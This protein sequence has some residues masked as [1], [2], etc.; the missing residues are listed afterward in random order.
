MGL[1]LLVLVLIVT[2]LWLWMGR[3]NKRGRS[4][5][6]ITATVFFVVLTAGESALLIALHAGRLLYLSFILLSLVYW[7][8]GL[9]AIVL[10]WRRSSSDYYIAVSNWSKATREAARKPHGQPAARQVTD[11]D[12]D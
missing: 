7:L 11:P 12:P 10:L 3:A 9:R 1:A 6:R 8:A 4:W 2:G 5:A